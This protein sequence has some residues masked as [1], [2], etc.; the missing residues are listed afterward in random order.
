[1]AAPVRSPLPV[2]DLSKFFS[3]PD[4]LTKEVPRLAISL[5]ALDKCGK[6]HWSLMTA[7]DP[8]VLVTCDPGTLHVLNKARLAGRRIPYVL[9]LPHERPDTKII[10]AKDV[11]RF[12]HDAYKKLWAKY[13]EGMYALASDSKS[14][15]RTVVMDTATDLWHLAELAHFGKLRGNARIDIRT[16]LNADFSGIFWRLYKDRPDLNI[17]LIHKLRKEYKPKGEKG[18]D[19]WTGKYEREGFGKIGFAVDLCLRAGWDS[20]RRDFYTEIEVDQATRYGGGELSGKR[21][22]SKPFDGEQESGFGW[23]GMTVFPET[24]ENPEWWGL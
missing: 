2:S 14:G 21:W 3:S 22:Y 7:P 24:I 23:L 12:E 4:T 5:E 16:E 6:T 8:I 15:I 18:E 1:M 19:A 11:D 10:A 17:I 9:E 20:V 13:R